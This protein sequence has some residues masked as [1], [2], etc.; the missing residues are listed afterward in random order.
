MLAHLFKHEDTNLYC[1]CGDTSGRAIPAEPEGRRWRYV[2][3]VELQSR[4][5]RLAVDS[6]AAIADIAHR[7]YH[8]V[9]GWFHQQ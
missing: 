1:L 7:G 4:E 2:R 5:Q 8:F 3:A 9:H 6:D